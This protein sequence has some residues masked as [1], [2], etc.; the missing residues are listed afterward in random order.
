[1]NP[2]MTPLRT[3]S[4]WIESVAVDTDDG[5]P[6]D[7]TALPTAS[8]EL[9]LRDLNGCVVY[10]TTTAETSLTMGYGSIEWIIR[11]SAISR[12]RPGPYVVHV[13]VKTGPDTEHLFSADMAIVD[14][15]WW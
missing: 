6:F 14:G 9:Q 7:L 8:A 4:D 3:G 15:G 5:L 13:R 10:S 2:T 12:L 11:S 1:M